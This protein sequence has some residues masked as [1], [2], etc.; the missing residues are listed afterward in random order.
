[1]RD[2][3][4]V[5]QY[6][7][8]ILF[9]NRVYP[10][11]PGATGVMLADMAEGLAERGWA[12]TVLTSGADELPASDVI[13]GVRVERVGRSNIDRS[14]HIRRGL[15]YA[16]LYPAFLSRAFSLPAHD[17]IVTKTDPPMQVVL[18]PLIRRV[19]GGKLI[20]W[21]QDVYP[22]VAAALE[23]IEKEG[24][25]FKTLKTVSTWA[26]KQQD[27]VVAVGRCM[28]QRLIDRGVTKDLIHVVPNW[29]DTDNLRP[30]A[31]PQNAFRKERGWDGKFVVMY[32]G[33]MGLAHPFDAILDA[34]VDLHEND[35]V[36]FAFVGDGPRLPRL[37]ASVEE[38]GLKNVRFLPFQPRERLAES[39][40]SADLHLVTMEEKL[41]GLVVPSKVYGVLAVSRPL[42]F[43]GPADS[44]SAIV[45]RDEQLGEV[46]EVPS[47][48]DLSRLIGRYVERGTLKNGTE[49]VASWGAAPAVDSFEAV[50]R[51]VGA[52]ASVGR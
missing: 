51:S 2:S 18:G 30:I 9:I 10:P 1:M 4:P 25:L 36:V 38:R 5:E 26:L 44:E 31:H 32:S 14:S 45:I 43:M 48:A 35:D 22:E 15:Q 50:L 28:K 21:A 20:H 6:N 34:A 11:V 27:A 40:S 39:L 52:A 3:A 17:V 47:G 42:V 46:M 29:A 37:K 33:N 13:N 23:V 8:S 12:V 16:S 49:T 7:R 24:V 41:S 19:K